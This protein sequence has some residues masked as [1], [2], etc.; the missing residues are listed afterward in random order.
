MISRFFPILVICLVVALAALV[1]A[2]KIHGRD[3]ARQA[4]EL[5]SGIAQIEAEI[6]LLRAESYRLSHPERLEK[7]ARTWLELGIAVP[8]QIYDL[9]EGVNLVFGKDGPEPMLREP[10]L[11]EKS[12]KVPP[13][14]THRNSLALTQP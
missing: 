8:S 4:S 14:N 9:R 7:L 12:L 1:N 10:A 5:R 2:L 13:K 11:Q 6:E 3:E